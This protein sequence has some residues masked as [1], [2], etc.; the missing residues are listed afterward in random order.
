MTEAHNKAVECKAA[1]RADWSSI[2]S[3]DQADLFDR[4]EEAE[5]KLWKTM[6]YK[7]K[8]IREGWRPGGGDGT[9]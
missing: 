5:R 4:L 7:P 8:G 1:G 6:R 9:P 2:L 3:G